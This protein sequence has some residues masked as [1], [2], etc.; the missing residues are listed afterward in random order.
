MLEINL[1]VA[2][3][4]RTNKGAINQMRRD[5]KVPGVFYIKGEEPLTYVVSE[6][7]L[8]L[9][10]DFLIKVSK[11]KNKWKIKDN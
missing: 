10:D 9:N 11:R 7:D 4:T 6:K 8:I 5:G 2:K 1:D 3:R